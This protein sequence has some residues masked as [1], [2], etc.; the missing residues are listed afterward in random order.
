M[1]NQKVKIIKPDLLTSN[2]RCDKTYR[3]L[4]DLMLLETQEYLEKRFAEFNANYTYDTTMGSWLFDDGDD[5]SVEPIRKGKVVPGS[6]WAVITQG[7]KRDR[8]QYRTEVIKK[9]ES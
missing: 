1:N 2:E 9:M 7:T 4:Y 5:G 8:A 3:E 6:V